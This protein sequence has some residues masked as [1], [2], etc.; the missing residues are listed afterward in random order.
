M[1]ANERFQVI[2]PL[3]DAAGWRR[4]LAVD[5]RGGA[6]R[7]VVL[8]YAPPGL[9]DDPA[10]LAALVRDAEAAARVHH[11]NAVPVLGLETLGEAL[12]AVEAH[13][14]GATLR[15]LLDGGGRLPPELVLRAGL[16]ACA[17]LAAVHAVDAGEGQPLAHGALAPER[18]LV[19]DDG[20]CLLSG[21]GTGGAG[22]PA[23]DLRALGAIL[24]EC[25][26]GEPPPATPLPLEGPGIPPALAA[27]VDRALG[28]GGHE[29]FPSA[30]ALGEALAG[31][32]PAAPPEAMAAYLEAILPAG[33]GERGEVL[34][35]VARALSPAGAERAVPV[36][37]APE[38][39]AEVSAELVAPLPARR[40]AAVVQPATVPAPAA[41]AAAVA[42]PATASAALAAAALAA[43]APVEL[44]APVL[45][46]SAAAAAQPAITPAQPPAPVSL[47]PPPDAA[48]T[49][50][51]PAPPPRSALPI[52]LGIAVAMAGVGFGIGFVLSRS[53]PRAASTAAAPIA[54]APAPAPVAAPPAPRATA[55][56]PEP[57]ADAA[58]AERAPAAPE[59]R[60]A[61][62]AP[63]PSLAI[64]AEPE[65]DV[66]VDGKR[67]GR[68]PVTVPV[69]RGDHRV[70]LR[71]AAEG[72]DVQ[73]RV[74]A[75]GPGTA[76]RFAL[77][78]GVLAVTAPPG[79]EVRV[80]GRRVGEGSVKV[81]LWEGA[82]LVEARLGE[83]RVQERFE[84]RPNE[85]WT[86]AVTPTP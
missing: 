27:V 18:V 37:P 81:Q 16:D 35:M 9:T 67:V 5:R 57:P 4:A 38:I 64:T 36:R 42:A 68:S 15:A 25:L 32:L 48:I 23:G 33:E 1:T 12:V 19:A 2:T 83:A 11:P 41:P 72:V 71:N 6:P 22:T 39:T 24:H 14:R 77:G 85:T 28:A 7:A 29:P 50:A 53:Q 56:A 84:L 80:D 43:A 61:A 13:R 60:R 47:A 79:T 8:A 69:S 51:A 74:T 52:V 17:A 62:A 49:F 65:G 3:H 45:V 63:A 10:R 44:P 73:K 30:D 46:G 55:P 76:V 59:P 34:R 82:H 86:Y 31:A 40:P 66:Y 78:R 58:P 54:A 70:R 26:A 75:R 21:L 20:S